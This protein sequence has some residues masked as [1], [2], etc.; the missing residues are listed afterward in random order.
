MVNDI[1]ENA[2]NQTIII[3]YCMHCG[4]QNIYQLNEYKNYDDN[5]NGIIFCVGC[6]KQI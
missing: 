1:T 4:T 2:Y 6:G 5:G 3:V